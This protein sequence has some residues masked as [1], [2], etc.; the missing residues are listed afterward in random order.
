MT[1]LE[2]ELAEVKDQSTVTAKF[3][4]SRTA[5]RENEKS[6]ASIK[7]V[8]DLMS[9]FTE[10]ARQSI[11]EMRRLKWSW[12]ELIEEAEASEDEGESNAA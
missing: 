1:A 4:Q 10:N 9:E 2:R 8:S 6:L 7:P 5:S 11:E 3:E 12:S